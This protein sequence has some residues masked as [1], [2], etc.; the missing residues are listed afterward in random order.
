M[1]PEGLKNKV[2]VIETTLLSDAQKDDLKYAALSHQ[3]GSIPFRKSTTDN[4]KEHLS[5]ILTRRLPQSFQDAAKVT[6]A[7]GLTYLWIDSLCIVQE[8]EKADFDEEAPKMED[9]YSSAYCVLA[10]SSASGASE[11][12]LKR[13]SGTEQCPVKRVDLEHEGR[14]EFLV[15]PAIDDFQRD[16][17]ESTLE[18]RGWVLQ[19]HALAR[20][21]LFFT[22]NQTYF[23]CGDGIRCETLTKLSK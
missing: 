11:G 1:S 21:T 18:T 2:R 7:L 15:A 6:E 12:F 5:G 13:P 16:V 20:R 4:I 23:E 22:N 3:W 14:R 9:I 17:L 10:A 8:G 19:E